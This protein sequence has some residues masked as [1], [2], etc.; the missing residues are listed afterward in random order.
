MERSL[1][2]RIERLPSPPGML[3]QL[4]E[5][6][7]DS[8]VS[9]GA[10]AEII[11]QG[12]TARLL[13]AANSAFFGVRAEVRSAEQALVVLGVHMLRNLLLVNTVGG[14]LRGLSVSPHFGVAQ[15]WEHSLAT[16][17]LSKILAARDARLAPGDAFVAGLLHDIGKVGMATLFSDERCVIL[18]PSPF[19]DRKMERAVFGVDH[20]EVGVALAEAWRLPSFATEAIRGHH[21]PEAISGLTRVVRASDL[22]TYY[23]FFPGRVDALRFHEIPAHVAKELEMEPATFASLDEIAE[24][25]RVAFMEAQAIAGG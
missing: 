10:V 8:A 23:F 13:R 17:V 9:F 1:L 18:A 22:L 16:A 3:F 20:V 11:E 21:G 4:E 7:Q 25:A 5:M 19:I 6:L 12:L 24:E 15:Y 14:T 2:A